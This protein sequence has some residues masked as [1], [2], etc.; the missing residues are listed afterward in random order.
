MKIKPKV[1]RMLKKNKFKIFICKEIMK[2][3]TKY[4]A[5]IL[6]WMNKF[7]KTKLFIVT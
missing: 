4:Y 5:K 1:K 2:N 7:I 3:R 6:S